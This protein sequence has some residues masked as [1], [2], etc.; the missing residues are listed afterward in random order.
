MSEFM[1]FSQKPTFQ[2]LSY[3][4]IVIV[5]AYFEKAEEKKKHSNTNLLAT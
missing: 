5:A 3:F 4:V 1:N 2:P